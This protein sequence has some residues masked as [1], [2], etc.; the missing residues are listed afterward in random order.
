MVELALSYASKLVGKP[1]G[2]WTLDLN[3]IDQDEPF[4]AFDTDAPDPDKVSSASCAGLVNL[5]RRCLH[6]NV[7]G[8]GPYKGGT[9]QWF[10]TLISK[11][12]LSSIDID[13][14]Y[15]TGTLLLRNYKDVEDQ[16]HVAVIYEAEETLKKSKIIHSCYKGIRIDSYFD[17]YENYF[18]HICLPENW[19][20]KKF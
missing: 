10:L 4:F 9:Y 18:S 11:G 6:L 14:S 1:Y 15:P 19:L 5:M 20:F 3:M 12:L 7:P 17:E 2:A 16:G 8:T 13:L